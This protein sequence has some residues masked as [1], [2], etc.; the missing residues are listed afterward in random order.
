MITLTLPVS[1]RLESCDGKEGGKPPDSS[2]NSSL[3]LFI[4][5]NKH[6]P[7]NILNESL[8]QP[9]AAGMI[10]LLKDEGLGFKG[11]SRL[12]QSCGWVRSSLMPKWKL[13]SY[14][15][16][17]DPMDHTIVGSLSLLQRIFPTQGSNPGLPHCRQTLYCLS[18]LAS[19][20]PRKVCKNRP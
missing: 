11:R 8:S 17:C 18:Q 12:A 13:P 4:T 1:E 10:L 3:W 2:S 19:H 16:L 15:R 6:I 9:F 5:K 14:V 20:L 7:L